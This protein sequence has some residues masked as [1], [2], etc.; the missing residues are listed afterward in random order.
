MA[1]QKKPTSAAEFRRRQ[2][3]IV[4]V[5]DT[6]TVELKRSDMMTMLMNGSMPMPMIEAAMGFE[7]AMDKQREERKRQG[8]PMQTQAE[9]YGSMD[10]TLMNDMLTAMKHYAVIH[11]VDP[12]IVFG[13]D[14]NPN[15]L[16][17]NLLTATQLLSLFYASPDSEQKEAPVVTKD[18]ATEFRGEPAADAGDA[19]PDS[20]AVRTTAKLLDLQT[21]QAISA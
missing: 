6:L 5:D 19:G 8:L 3:F 14:G 2:T 10:K 21:R 15:H 12:V 11:A 9:Q 18:E 17:V 20:P 16:D 7:A 13:N 1:V 4:E